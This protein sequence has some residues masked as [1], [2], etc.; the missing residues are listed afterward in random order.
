MHNA[1]KHNSFVLHTKLVCM[2]VYFMLLKTWKFLG[3][4][5]VGIIFF[6]LMRKLWIYHCHMFVI[7]GPKWNRI[8][9]IIL[10][11]TIFTLKQTLCIY[12][13][14]IHLKIGWTTL[15]LELGMAMYNNKWDSV[16]KSYSDKTE[17][18]VNGKSG[19][20]STRGLEEETNPVLGNIYYLITLREW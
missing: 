3:E 19:V 10:L 4:L 15:I 8:L 18:I 9:C 1:S 5:K 14:I 13:V 20:V 17:I 7:W 11:N 6:F 16:C 2:V 12:V